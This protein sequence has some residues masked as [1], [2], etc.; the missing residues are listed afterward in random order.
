MR[1]VI[2]GA[3]GVG[4]TLG[5]R[6]VE[7][8]H[9]VAWLAR[10]A[11]LAALREGLRLESPNGDLRLGRQEAEDDPRKLGRADA[12][13]VSVKTYSL[14]EL[15]PRLAPLAGPDTVVLPLQ[16]GIEAR[17][18]LANALP[19]ARVLNG[20]VSVKAHLDKPGLVIC[21]SGF[22]RMR[23]AGAG[24]TPLAEALN[25]GKGLEAVVSPDIDADVWRKFVMLS[26]FSAVACL[27]RGNIG[28]VL[29]DP[30]AHALLLE[31]VGEALEVARARGVRLEGSPAQIVDAQ[32]RDLPREGKPS[33]LED[34]LAG[35][36]LEIDSLSGTVARLGAQCGVPTPFHALATRVLAMHKGG[37]PK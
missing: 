10:G 3:G 4:G 35:R 31:A 22:C 33:M 11:N 30:A 32:V 25:Q 18:V 1:F 9:Q 21:R 16:N 2:A 5:A 36:P 37:S 17:D 19:A 20:M 15:A 26:S 8:G 24:A 29:D 34:L 7:A 23:F 12:L 27:T 13:V 14:A 6:M 28:R